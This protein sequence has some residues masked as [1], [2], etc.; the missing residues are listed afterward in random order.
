M[1]VCVKQTLTTNASCTDPA[2]CTTPTVFGDES[3][4]LKHCTQ[5]ELLPCFLKFSDYSVPREDSS[6][7]KCKFIMRKSSEQARRD[8]ASQ[9]GDQASS[10]SEG[11]TDRWLARWEI[12]PSYYQY[13]A[14]ECLL[15]S[16]GACV[17][18]LVVGDNRVFRVRSSS[19]P[20]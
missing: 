19:V 1:T 16:P 6:N 3:E 5:E 12:D 11:S 20:C 2:Y 17:G 4:L 7:S 15:V 14:C 10:I 18:W 8:C 9:L 13:Q